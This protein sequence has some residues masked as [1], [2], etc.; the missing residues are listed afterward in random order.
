MS[1]NTESFLIL[2]ETQLLEPPD[3]III[4]DHK[5]ASSEVEKDES[6]SIPIPHMP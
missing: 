6:H 5:D 4:C 3:Q 2:V 1:G